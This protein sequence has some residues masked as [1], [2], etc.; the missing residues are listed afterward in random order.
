MYMCVCHG[1]TSMPYACSHIAFRALKHPIFRTTHIAKRQIPRSGLICSALCILAISTAELLTPRMGPAAIISAAKWT[2]RSENIHWNETRETGNPALFLKICCQIHTTATFI[3]RLMEK[4]LHHQAH[5][6]SRP[7]C[8]PFNI[9]SKNCPQNKEVEWL[10]SRTGAQSFRT[11]HWKGGAGVQ[12]IAY[13]HICPRRCRISFSK[14]NN[15]HTGWSPFSSE[16]VDINLGS[17]A[18]NPRRLISA[19]WSTP[20]GTG[21]PFI[22]SSSAWEDLPWYFCKLSPLPLARQNKEILRMDNS[23]PANISKH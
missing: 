20:E 3:I 11:Q 7:S 9:G 1:H 13:C 16:L 14:K 22:D 5:L 18:G 17:Q 12:V 10:K 15:H 23:L 6:K 8:S 19:R 21:E 4:I 2:W